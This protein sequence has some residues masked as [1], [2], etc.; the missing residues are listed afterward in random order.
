MFSAVN[1]SL[2]IVI[3]A[4]N[5]ISVSFNVTSSVVGLIVFIIFEHTA[6]KIGFGWCCMIGAACSIA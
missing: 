6:T 3:Y 1:L 5:M 2:H 4:V